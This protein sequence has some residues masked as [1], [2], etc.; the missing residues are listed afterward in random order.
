VRQSGDWH[1]RNRSRRHTVNNVFLLKKEDYGEQR[2]WYV[3][4]PHN[5]R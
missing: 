2:A 5:G 1:P 3:P 4:V